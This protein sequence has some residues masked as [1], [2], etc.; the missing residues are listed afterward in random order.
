M[1]SAAGANAACPMRAMQ[2]RAGEGATRGLRE[3]ESVG[4]KQ[5]RLGVVYVARCQARRLFQNK[6]VGG[7][8]CSLGCG[9]RLEWTPPP[10]IAAALHAGRGC[11]VS[12]SASSFRQSPPA[13]SR[14]NQGEI[15]SGAQRWTA[16]DSQAESQTDRQTREQ[17]GAALCH[18]GTRPWVS[19]P[20]AQ[21]ANVIAP[22]RGDVPSPQRPGW[23]LERLSR[24]PEAPRASFAFCRER[25]VLRALRDQAPC[26]LGRP[27]NC[28]VILRLRR[29]LELRS[30][31][32]HGA[33]LH[34]AAHSR[35]RWHN[36]DM[37]GTFVRCLAPSHAAI[38]A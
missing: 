31:T 9:D 19:R 38:L 23:T 32:R 15:G 20:L 5:H 1:R 7:C 14:C 2:G 11:L 18:A 12:E 33:V 13:M 21:P 37:S 35:A 29:M 24:R 16:S 26:L 22:R 34:P 6:N 3:G 27:C 30:C 36:L 25:L 10:V 17:A 28:P 8:R 4:A